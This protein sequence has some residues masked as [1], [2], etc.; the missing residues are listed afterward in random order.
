MSNGSLATETLT[1]A[2]YERTKTINEYRS[3]DTPDIDVS[4]VG[5]FQVGDLTVQVLDTV[6]DYAQLMGTLFDFDLIGFQPIFLA[7]A[8][9]V[10]LAGLMTFRLAEPRHHLRFGEPAVLEAGVGE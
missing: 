1:E 4:Q 10:M 7:A 8:G 6:D 9:L 2:I 3:L 5:E